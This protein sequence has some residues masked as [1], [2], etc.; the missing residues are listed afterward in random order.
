MKKNGNGGRTPV[1]D[2]PEPLVPSFSVWEGRNPSR[3]RPSV[4]CE[5]ETEIR[6]TLELSNEVRGGG[7]T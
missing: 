3:H 7:V 2:C 1:G 5:D 4:A 6:G